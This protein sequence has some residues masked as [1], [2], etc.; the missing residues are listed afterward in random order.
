MCTPHLRDRIRRVKLAIKSAATP[1]ARSREEIRK[2]KGRASRAA[3]V[4]EICA[5]N[6]MD[7]TPHTRMSRRSLLHMIGTVAGSAA[8]YHAMTEMGYAQESGYSG[9]PKL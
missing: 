1:I 7:N 5:R 3:R 8:M 4:E 6:T 9:P 2:G